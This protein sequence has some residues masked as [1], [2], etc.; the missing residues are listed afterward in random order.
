MKNYS[1][2]NG[3][4]RDGDLEQVRIEAVVTLLKGITTKQH[5][6]GPRSWHRADSTPIIFTLPQHEHPPQFVDTA[7][8]SPSSTAGCLGAHREI[9]PMEV[10]CPHLGQRVSPSYRI[11]IMW[12]ASTTS[13]NL[14][15][16]PRLGTVLGGSDLHPFC[17]CEG[18]RPLDD[19]S[20]SYRVR[21]RLLSKT[22]PPVTKVWSGQAPDSTSVP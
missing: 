14:V 1:P 4:G 8:W 5:K 21:S 16:S 10:R 18:P 15:A 12:S 9:Q 11:I 20:V 22:L 3:E 6:M 7:K 2:T 17:L 13:L 19:K